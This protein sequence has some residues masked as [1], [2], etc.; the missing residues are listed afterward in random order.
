[1]KKKQKAGK[2]VKGIAQ[3]LEVTGNR[4]TWRNT[5]ARV[6]YIHVQVRSGKYPTCES[7][8][9]RFGVST[10]T[11]ERDL[12]AMRNT[13]DLPLKFSP[14]RKGYY[15]WKDVPAD[16]PRPKLTSGDTLAFC[17]A[18]RALE[19]FRGTDFAEVFEHSLR[20]IMDEVEGAV[21]FEWDALDT[22]V[23]FGPRGQRRAPKGEIAGAV[24]DGLMRQRELELEYRKLDSEK[25]ERRSIQPLHLR[26]LGDTLFLFA[27]DP[28]RTDGKVRRF[29][30][31]RMRNVRVTERKFERPADFDPDEL[32]KHSVGAYG[33]E[34]PVLVRLR[35]SAKAARFVEERP[36]HSTQRIVRAK[37]KTAKTK[38]GNGA[39]TGNGNG[40]SGEDGSAE[41]T[42][43]VA[44]TPELEQMILFGGLDVEV[45]EPA[46]LRE[47][48]AEIA[49][50]IA[51]RV[52]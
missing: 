9:E 26:A 31:S 12:E 37:K 19:R 15:Y 44:V 24:S 33:G 48:I 6:R 42:M 8:A 32:M 4:S 22:L 47:R 46:S 43:Q 3:L 13:M 28:Q 52:G 1:M 50:G 45:L 35:L 27:L 38:R 25:Y 5:V 30:L 39:A 40:S 2:P 11:I 51:G 36:L 49:R 29:V 23:S 7:I 10:R 18:L 17:L 16:L 41:L 21:E 14:E 34:E 20:K